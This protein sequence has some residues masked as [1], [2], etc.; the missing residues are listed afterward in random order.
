MFD[1]IME[2]DEAGAIGVLEIRGPAENK[3]LE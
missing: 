2:L 3:S 1:L